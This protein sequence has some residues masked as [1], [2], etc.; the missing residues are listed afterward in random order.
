M[1]MDETSPAARG[2][3]AVIRISRGATA[4]ATDGALGTVHQIIMD[5]RTGELQALVIA[6]SDERRLEVP[7]THVVRATGGTVHLDVSKAQLQE[8]PE[9]APPYNPNQYVPVR[10]NPFL[11]PSEASRG[12]RYSERPVVTNIE[13][14]A[15]GVVVPQ[16]S[17]RTADMIASITK[18]ETETYI[19]PQQPQTDTT[20]ASPTDGQAGAVVGADMSPEAGSTPPSSLLT[21][22]APLIERQESDEQAATVA[23]ETTAQPQSGPYP[24]SSLTPTAPLIEHLDEDPA[25]ETSAPSGRASD[26][27]AE[28]GAGELPAAASGSEDDFLTAFAVPVVTSGTSDVVPPTALSAGA[29]LTDGPDHA[30]NEV[31][32]QSEKSAETMKEDATMEGS[33]PPIDPVHTGA[34]SDTIH[35]DD[36]H[37][38]E[39]L[40]ASQQASTRA[41]PPEE[42]PRAWAWQNSAYSAPD[43]SGSRLSWVPAVALGTVIVGVAAWSAYRTIR[44]GRRKA[45]EAAQNARISA[46]SLRSSMLDSVRDAGRSA[47]GVA[48]SVR[49]SAQEIAANPRDSAANALSNLSDIPARYRWFRRGMRAGMRASRLRRKTH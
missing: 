44:R 8:H 10:E 35:D 22:T 47:V 26:V 27:T 12:A 16:E 13:H 37:V 49:A 6:T 3:T 17:T 41:T 31:E 7:A 28:T 48:Q 1:T 15:V 45:A 42:S 2:T 5:Q 33:P 11:A 36:Q 9:L 4:M 29:G 20:A 19:P 46:E 18:P 23:D 25:E 39:A 43:E 14:D 21:P 38:S 24:P 32:I 30:S 34:L 40:G